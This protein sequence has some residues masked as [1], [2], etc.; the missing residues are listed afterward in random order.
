[1]ALM[2]LL[3][4]VMWMAPQII[5]PSLSLQFEFDATPALLYG[6]G[7]RHANVQYKEIAHPEGAA[8]M[9]SGSFDG[10][11]CADRSMTT[12]PRADFLQVFW[13]TLGSLAMPH[14]QKALSLGDGSGTG[15]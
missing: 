12:A 4:T 8:H 1:M 2:P 13:S 7:F 11:S 9:A 15:R 6:M 10:V 3:G 5:E 14:V